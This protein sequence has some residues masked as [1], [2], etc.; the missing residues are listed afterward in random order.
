MPQTGLTIVFVGQA[1]NRRTSVPD[2]LARLGHRVVQSNVVELADRIRTT[3]PDVVALLLTRG[4]ADPKTL[5][6]SIRNARGWRPR[7]VVAIAR[8]D[9]SDLLAERLFEPVDSGLLDDLWVLPLTMAQLQLRLALLERK[10]VGSEVQA[11]PTA[12]PR[13]LLEMIV[14]GVPLEDVLARIEPVIQEIV[15][16]ATALVRIHGENAARIITGQPGRVPDAIVEL[17]STDSRQQPAATPCAAAELEHA[18]VVAA[19]LTREDRWPLFCSRAI[20][21]G[22][23][24]CAAFPIHGPD[25]VPLGSL[26]ILGSAGSAQL[27]T[28]QLD[29]GSL[30]HWLSVAVERQ[31]NE[32]SL[33]R[34]EHRFQQAIMATND[35]IWEVD[36]ETQ[37]IYVS[38]QVLALL[39]VEHPPQPQ[40][41][42]A[43]LHLLQE[44]ERTPA[45]EQMAEHLAGKRPGYEAEHRVPLPDGSMRWLL[46]RGRIM[47]RN[48]QGEPRRVVGSVRDITAAKALE[49]QL[50]R[51]RTEAEQANQTKSQFLAHMSHEIRTPLNVMLGVTDLM[52]HGRLNAEQRECLNSIRDNGRQLLRLL[53]DILDVSRIEAGKL[54]LQETPFRLRECLQDPVRTIGYRAR[55]KNIEPILVLGENLPQ[56]LIGDSGRLQQVLLNLLDNAVKFTSEGEVV[57]S[58][59]RLS[60]GAQE[61]WLEFRIR[62]T[63]PGISEEVRTKLFEPFAQERPNEPATKGTG[64]GL[65]ICRNLC[66]L[67]AGTIA[68]SPQRGQGSEFVVRIPLQSPVE[69]PTPF[70]EIDGDP[71]KGLEILVVEDHPTTRQVLETMLRGWG[72]RP[73][74]H[75]SAEDA[76]EF[77]A[78]RAITN[79]LPQGVVLDDRIGEDSGPAMLN[80]WARTLDVRLPTVLLISHASTQSELL[81]EGRRPNVRPIAKPVLPWELL[82]ALLDTIGVASPTDSSES[83][84]P[85]F[86]PSARA[87]RVLL[88]EDNP[89]NRRLANKLLKRL[90]HHVFEAEDGLQAVQLV[91][92]QRF[93]VVL[94]DLQM[95][96]LDG[97]EATRQIRA[98]ESEKARPRMPIVAM[99]AHAFEEDRQRCLAAGMDGFL[100]K[101]LDL[102]R[103]DQT[104][105]ELVPA[106]RK[107]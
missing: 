100:P 69:E 23:G 2:L 56:W 70:A 16:H 106:A 76:H 62:D 73:V 58:V 3:R 47:N 59:Q 93:D 85:T 46:A 15:P 79:Q 65:A 13:G 53:G 18:A 32:D 36:L 97:L 22:I 71:L 14:Q 81:R 82:D 91:E 12:L 50:E 102:A 37:S 57:L 43:W 34:Q 21:S 26:C 40:N 41:L 101:P 6:D 11:S 1:S 98:W 104:M 30:A 51:A 99:T 75:A 67:M 28:E 84:E 45:Q 39:N 7:H 83:N 78:A 63:G 35:G 49:Q 105:R 64:L 10:A 60:V 72:V 27:I 42:E 74:I 8:S 55:R 89:A 19:D 95:P 44:D 86:Q 80:R 33:R 96:L 88:V 31:R 66:D 77:L 38:Q 4:D 94:M 48:A 68:L 107:V 9:E 25:D 29:L 54:T 90:G 61:D 103:F 24:W 52:L 17:L 5:L 92:R 20:A 87:L